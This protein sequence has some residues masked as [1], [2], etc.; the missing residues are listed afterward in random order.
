MSTNPLDTTDYKVP[1]D[2]AD[3]AIALREMADGEDD[4]LG[5]LLKVAAHHLVLFAAM[6]AAKDRKHLQTAKKI[7]TQG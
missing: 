6:P 2:P 5:R 3:V 7:A 1:S 4:Y